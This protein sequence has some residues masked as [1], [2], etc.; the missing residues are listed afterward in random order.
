MRQFVR[1][2][3]ARYCKC[4]CLCAMAIFFGLKISPL[5]INVERQDD[6]VVRFQNI[7][8]HFL[9]LPIDPICTLPERIKRAV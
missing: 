7:G 9:H 4:A 3:V 8:I 5:V 2:L 6:A 1:Q